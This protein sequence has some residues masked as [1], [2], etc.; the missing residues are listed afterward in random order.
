MCRKFTTK[1]VR[2]NRKDIQ[3]CYLVIQELADKEDLPIV[4]KLKKT[5]KL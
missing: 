3:S 4:L 1:K 5:G 2:G